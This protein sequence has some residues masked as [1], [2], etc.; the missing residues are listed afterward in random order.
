MAMIIRDALNQEFDEVAS[1]NVEAY[2][3]Y[4]QVLTLEDWK[5][6]QTNL[7]NVVEIA[8]PGRLII[9]EQDSVLVGSVIYHLLEHQVVVCFNQNGHPCGC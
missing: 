9:A 5:K 8:K 4:S 3:E 6:M 2:R 7:S 1:L